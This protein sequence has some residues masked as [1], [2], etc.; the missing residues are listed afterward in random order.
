[1]KQT[2][3]SILDNGIYQAKWYSNSHA[4]IAKYFD[5]FIGSYDTLPCG[6]TMRILHDYTATQAPSMM[7]LRAHISKISVR[8]DIK[9]R[10]AHIYSDSFL[11]LMMTNLT[12]STLLFADRK[13][14]PKEEL[15]DAVVW[16]L[17]D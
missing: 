11:P 12:M 14:F 5:W 3:F 2:T 6:S 7:Q 15:D 4:D 10:I 16:L 8:E 9:L 13:F 1:M 17:E